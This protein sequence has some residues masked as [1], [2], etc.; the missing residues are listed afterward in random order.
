MSKS[1]VG[2]LAP[3]G[4]AELPDPPRLSGRKWLA[5]IG[6]G[7]VLAGMSIGT[8]EWLF[9]PGVS[10][11][12][13]ASLFWLAMSSIVLQAFCNL[14]FMRYAIYCGEPINVGILRCWP[15]P[16]LWMLFFAVLDISSI[17]PYNAS[18]AAVPLSA[19]ILG[20]L[21]TPDDVVLV[22]GLGIAIFLLA[23]VPLVFGSTVYRML[24]FVMAAKLVVVL[25][26]LSIIALTMISFTVAWDVC[27]GFV[28]FGTV[29]LRPDTLIVDR[30]FSVHEK[31]AGGLEYFLKGTWERRDDSVT[32]EMLIV[33]AGKPETVKLDLSKSE[34][35]DSA[36]MSVWQQV[37]TRTRQFVDTPN[38]VF[39]LHDPDQLI[40]VEG[41]VRNH[42]DWVAER[43]EI[44][45]S[46]QEIR[47]SRL[48]ELSESDR[49][50]IENHLRH[51]G[52]AYRNIVGYWQENK[53]L[54]PLDWAMVVAFVAIAGAGGMTNSMF[55]NYARDKGWGM[56]KHVGAI[57]S[58]FGAVTVG[59]SHSGS[60]FPLD[61]S[62]LAK[63][64]G[65]LKHI[66]L[67]QWIW[68]AAS[69]IGMALPCMMS[70]EFIR[71]ASVVG[72]RVAAMSA[73]GIA[74]RYP[75]Y[76]GM[77]WMLTL[78]CGFLILAPGQVSAGDQ[79]ARRWAD[80]IWC[81]TSLAKR[82]GG[83]KQIYYGIL[84]VYAVWGL[85]VL[86]ALSA[87]QTAKIAAVLQNIALGFTALMSLYV[88][89]RLMPKELHPGWPHQLG[90]ILCGLFFLGISGALIFTNYL[91]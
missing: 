13:G 65:W 15:G 81:G 11:Q 22:R 28:R 10:A 25:G 14:M 5:M 90:V 30:H 55:S 35:F 78:L 17:W 37:M 57:P 76:G 26:Y 44:S 50:R 79:I 46:K 39:E 51:E 63:W 21:P 61:E 6:P 60:V 29:P 89:R 88:T 75:A 9:G 83:V 52:L 36:A 34:S 32:G 86:T 72:D 56:G 69:I 33:E 53:K 2:A 3:W 1:N 58:A 40:R 64:R 77:F 71:N 85:L 66:R 87:V 18:N 49:A 42:H 7:V 4:Q 47:V 82:L 20:R 54:P 31:G 19:A 84:M 27:T 23:F 38:F 73:E 68:I 24:E 67:D 41:I 70:L 91:R 62:N 45:K 59:L 8:G 43:I 48:E 80:M 12:Y 74:A 16:H